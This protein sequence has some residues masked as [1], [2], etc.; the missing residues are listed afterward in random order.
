M[1]LAP[2]TFLAHITAGKNCSEYCSPDD[3]N[4]Q[5]PALLVKIHF[6]CASVVYSVRIFLPPF[7]YILGLFIESALIASQPSFY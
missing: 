1:P 7:S 4:F 3:K 2:V 6:L 5:F